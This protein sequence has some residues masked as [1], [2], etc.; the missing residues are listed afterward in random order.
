MSEQPKT[1][2][3]WFESANGYYWQQKAIENAKKF[4]RNQ[5][6]TYTSLK[7]AIGCAFIWKNTNEG[8]A[9]WQIVHDSLSY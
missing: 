4:E 2:I 5:I 8:Q 3:E 9:Y 7:L 1:P 6:E